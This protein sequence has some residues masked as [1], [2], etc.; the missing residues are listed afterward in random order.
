MSVEADFVKLLASSMAQSGSG[1]PHTLAA[2]MT[3]HGLLFDKV[4]N[5]E[6]FYETAVRLKL[7]SLPMT[8][9]ECCLFEF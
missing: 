3:T 8:H 2:A 5:I 1:I 6:Y 4:S 7:H 9:K